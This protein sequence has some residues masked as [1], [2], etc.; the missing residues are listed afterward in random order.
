M[1]VDNLKEL[2]KGLTGFGADRMSDVGPVAF[3][4]VMVV[5][6]VSSIFIGYLYKYFFSTDT[7]GSQIHRS[8]PLLGI[9]VTAIFVTIQFSLP[10]SLGLLGAL[11]IVR[12]RT[13]IKEPE[14]IG[15]L[16]LVIASS[17]TCATF[18]FLFQGIVLTI[19]VVGLVILRSGILHRIQDDGVFIVTVPLDDFQTLEPQLA[20]HV[21]SMIKGG[22]IESITK[23]DEQVVVSYRFRKLVANDIAEFQ[24]VMGS[25]LRNQD[26]DVYLNQNH[27]A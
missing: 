6:L 23:R 3:V 13:P 12:F 15:F 25:V 26:F 22:R 2:V 24:K 16:M 19:A 9:S 1:T 11:S 17:I 10:L 14:E 18:N 20:S 4:F 5:A 27:V 8:F 7:T 21:Q